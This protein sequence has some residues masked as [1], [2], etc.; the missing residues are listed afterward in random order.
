MQKA[1]PSR[2]LKSV[3]SAP[4]P[5]PGGC[6]KT[7]SGWGPIICIAVS[8]AHLPTCW[9]GW[10]TKSGQ[11][12]PR[13]LGIMATVKSSECVSCHS[14]FKRCEWL[15]FLS[16]SVYTLYH[17]LGCLGGSYPIPLEILERRQLMALCV[18]EE[19]AFRSCR[20]PF[21]VFLCSKWHRSCHRPTSLP[22]R[23]IRF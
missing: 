21:L 5:W 15:R 9:L 19:C 17:C 3:L 4:W 2:W 22:L 14:N 6:G 7:Q 18:A 10:R 1:L 13:D 16:S 12:K 23:S 11:V 20:C 8:N